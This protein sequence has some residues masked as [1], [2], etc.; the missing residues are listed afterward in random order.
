M[1]PATVQIKGSIPSNDHHQD[2]Q[3]T[4]F[5]ICNGFDSLLFLKLLENNRKRIKTKSI[6][7]LII[8]FYN[9]YNFQ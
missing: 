9:I 6:V 2:D 8:F 5:G 4:N 7:V 3:Q 1:I